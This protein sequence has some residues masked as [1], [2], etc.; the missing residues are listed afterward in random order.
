MPTRNL[1]RNLLAYRF[2]NFNGLNTKS[3]RTLIEDNQARAILNIDFKN[4][5][6]ISKRP[7]YAKWGT[8]IAGSTGIQSM[9]TF[10]YNGGANTK[11]IV[12]SGTK[13][14]VYNSS[15]D[16]YDEL[17]TGYTTGLK[18]NFITFKD[19]CIWVNGT[20]VAKK[21][22]GTTVTT[23]GGT[24]PVCK[25]I[26]LHKN[27]VFM[28][29]A[30]DY[31]SRL[32]YSK[33]DDHETWYPTAGAGFFDVNPDDN[34]HI[35]GLAVL[36]DALVIYK[37]KKAYLLYGD[38]PTYTNGL[39]LWRVKDTSSSTGTVSQKSVVQIS[40]NLFYLS[41]INGVSK[42]FNED[43][44]DTTFMKDTVMSYEI[45]PTIAGLNQARLNQAEGIYWDYKYILSVPNGA[46]TTNNYNLCFD[47]IKNCWTI[48]NIPANC[49]TIYNTG[50]QE[51]LLFGST[52][53]GQ[54][55][56]MTPGT[57]NDDGVAIEAYYRT[58]DICRINDVDMPGNDK[59]YEYFYLTKNQD[60]NYTVTVKYYIDFSDTANATES[61]GSVA[62]DSVW[63]T[64]VWGT[65]KWGSTTDPTSNKRMNSRGKFI[66]FEFY[67]NTLNE[68]IRVRDNSFYYKGRGLR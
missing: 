44:T 13:V 23:L 17:D 51:L 58:K 21:Y 43:S 6:E 37:S 7:G 62:S 34:D 39:T 52:T 8:A 38:T 32:Y 61:V 15:T 53:T 63:G 45:I 57:Y 36:R 2:N 12:T 35:E 1:K 31:P 33:L 46:S 64:F 67:N 30:A 4:I 14:Y 5:G 68:D 19:Y 42:L 56:Y 50:S 29:G 22:D 49:W 16:V 66:S 3:D 9:Y 20:D 47:G 11:H 48:W 24:P 55:Y 41:A 18:F 26:M 10:T 40:D 65:D 54:V 60:S 25:Y 59:I 28:A 27:Y